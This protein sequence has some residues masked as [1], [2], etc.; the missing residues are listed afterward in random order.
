MPRLELK[1][2]IVVVVIAYNFFFENIMLE[3]C[4]SAFVALNILL[5]LLAGESKYE[6]NWKE[7]T[8]ML[9]NTLG[10]KKSV[11][12]WKNVNAF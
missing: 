12:E 10:P 3:M 1:M 11:D 9:N 4:A 6:E 7:L 2:V 8:Q 5:S